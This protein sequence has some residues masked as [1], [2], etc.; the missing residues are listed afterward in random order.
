MNLEKYDIYYWG[1]G[2]DYQPRIEEDCDADINKEDA[3][4]KPDTSNQKY[5]INTFLKVP[6]IDFNVDKNKVNQSKELPLLIMKKMLLRFMMLII[7]LMM[8][9]LIENM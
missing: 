1:L 2:K 9:M 4:D 7:L 6:N 8:Q 5:S 3:Y